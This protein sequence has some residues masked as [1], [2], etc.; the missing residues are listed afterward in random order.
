MGFRRPRV[1]AGLSASCVL[2]PAEAAAE[3]GFLHLSAL[4]AAGPGVERGTGEEVI[5]DADVDG[6]AHFPTELVWI[7]AE[8]DLDCLACFGAVFGLGGP[9]SRVADLGFRGSGSASEQERKATAGVAE[10]QGA[11]KKSE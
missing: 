9:A 8:A 2:L 1:R 11:E 6:Q 4:A 5:P 10:A 7:G 3:A